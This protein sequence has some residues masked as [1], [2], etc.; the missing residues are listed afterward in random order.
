MD[1]INEVLK[2]IQATNDNENENIHTVVESYAH[3]P[4]PTGKDVTFCGFEHIY[5]KVLEVVWCIQNNTFQFRI[6]LKDNPLTKRGI[7]TTVSSIFDPIGFVAPVL[8]EG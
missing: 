5:N 7:I 8:L 4:A 1:D 2:S 3:S 6:E